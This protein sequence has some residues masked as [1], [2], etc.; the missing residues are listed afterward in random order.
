MDDETTTEIDSENATDEEAVFRHLLYLSWPDHGVRESL[1]AFILHV[2]S[3]NRDLSLCITHTE[4]STCTL[5]S[6]PS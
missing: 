5:Y 1:L 6:T 4:A 2:E 3:T